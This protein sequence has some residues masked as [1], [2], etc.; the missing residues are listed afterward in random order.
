V[1]VIVATL[2]LRRV[3]LGGYV[4]EIQTEFFRETAE[5]PGHPNE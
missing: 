2:E 4:A 1:A 5:V 3:R